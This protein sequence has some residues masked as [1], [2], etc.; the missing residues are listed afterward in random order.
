MNART[1]V[2]IA[3]T[4]GVGGVAY[5]LVASPAKPTPVENP[6]PGADKRPAAKAPEKDVAKAPDKAPEKDVAKAPE[7]D[8]AK[9]AKAPAGDEEDPNGFN[10]PCPKVL[11]QELADFT[12]SYREEVDPQRAEADKK[13]NAKAPPADDPMSRAAVHYYLRCARKRTAEAEDKLPAAAQQQVKAMRQG[14]LQTANAYR[15]L[16]G[17][18]GSNGPEIERGEVAKEELLEQL[19]EALGP[20]QPALPAAVVTQTQ[21]ESERIVKGLRAAADRLG[22]DRPAAA[23]DAAAMKRAAGDLEIELKRMPPQAAMLLNAYLMPYA[24]APA[25]AIE[26]HP[27]GWVPGQKPPAK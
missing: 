20:N 18:A 19:S 11:E 9:A 1:L 21:R 10:R 25:P 6:T 3:L 24:A 4:L 27:A 17:K 7:K 15:A 23:S 22:A 12:V 16:L 26:F 13:A 2:V 14:L 8:V 5:L